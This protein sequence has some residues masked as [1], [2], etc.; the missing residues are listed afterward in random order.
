VLSL[1][2]FSDVLL[3]M[4]LGPLLPLLAIGAAH[5]VLHAALCNYTEN[6]LRWRVAGRDVR[7]LVL[8]VAY[9]AV[10]LLLVYYSAALF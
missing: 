5:S 4:A 9:P 10:V 8:R 2:C 3:Q 1:L 7:G 6:V